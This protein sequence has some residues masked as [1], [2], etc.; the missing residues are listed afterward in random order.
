MKNIKKSISV[1][2]LGYIGLPTAVYFASKGFRV[3]GYDANPAVVDAVNKGEAH[4]VE[5]ELNENLKSVVKRGS[6]SAFDTLQVADVY[7]ICVPTP[8]R[9]QGEKIQAEMTHVNDAVKKIIPILKAGD[10]LIL[11]S[12]S[13]VGTTEKI[14]AE[15]EISGTELNSVAIAYCPERV[16][17][18]QILQEL[19]ANDRVVGGINERSTEIVCD[20]YESI[21]S[22]KAL[23]TSAETAEMCKLVENSFRDLNIA[24]A[25]ELSLICADNNVNVFEL[26]RLANHHPRVDILTPGIGVGGH[27]LAVDPW[28][29]VAD[30]VEKAKLIKQAR[31]I[32]EF[33]PDFIVSELTK[34]IDHYKRLHRKPPI[35]TCFGLTYKPDIDDLRESPALKIAREIAKIAD[36][37]FVVEPNIDNSEEFTL[38]SIERALEITDIGVV[39]VKHTKFLDEDILSHRVICNADDYIGFRN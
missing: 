7:L 24:F 12:T 8:I 1:I 5:P 30:N 37:F 35:V 21:I 16:L 15:V 32:N 18:G 3:M 29:I 27:C 31:L 4:I 17:P 19:D 13:P 33:K 25:N 22:A 23:G 10:I 39:L 28:F 34:K 14:A 20:F 38:L 11:E 6:L 2:G 36:E 26:I 9:G